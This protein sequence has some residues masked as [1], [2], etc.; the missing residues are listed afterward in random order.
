[1][2]FWQLISAL[3][4]INLLSA[5]ASTNEREIYTS[6]KRPL[7]NDFDLAMSLLNRPVPADQQFMLA[8]AQQREEQWG[9][10]SFVAILGDKKSSPAPERNTS[11][12]FAIAND[13]NAQA[14]IGSE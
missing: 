10:N 12:Y 9:A 1:M 3:I 7:T 5:C 4:M 13:I 14:I 2:K 8:F 6:V 11:L